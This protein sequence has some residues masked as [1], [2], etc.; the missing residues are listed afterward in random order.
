MA[1]KIITTTEAF[2]SIKQD[3]ERIEKKDKDSTY[4]STFTYCSAWWEAYKNDKN[5]ELFIVLSYQNNKIAGIA[6][7]IIENKSIKI[8]KY[9]E[10]K[11][12]GNGDFLNIIID[13]EVDN[14][15]TVVKDIFKTIED[16]KD[17]WEKMNLR[18]IKSDS[19]L[20]S[21]LLKSPEYN[22]Y[23]KYQIECPKLD[24]KKYNS[25]E[26]Y[27]KEF[28]PS[29]LNKYRN[30]LKKNTDYTIEIV[31]NKEKNVYDEISQIHKKEKEFLQ[32]QKGRSERHSL[33]EDEKREKHLRKVFEDNENVLTLILRDKENEIIGYNTFYIY[34]RVLHS[35][36]IAY[37]PKYHDY[38]VGKILKYELIKYLFE[39]KIVDTLDFGAG[40]YAWK[41]EWTDDFV[42]NY[43]LEVYNNTS[44]AKNIK[45]IYKVKHMI[46]S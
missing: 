7:L 12:L 13:S 26:E 22:K 29:K 15:L 33:F 11:F 46:K 24:I 17:K 35:W 43:E 3:W 42:F 41:F 37:N 9:K 5:K 38:R 1:S 2:Y 10:L 20:S 44:K 40:R 19:K 4:Y 18:Y 27:E 23:F 14:P 25:F 39:S 36:N 28:K 45:R 31:N 21:Y 16:N 6:P 8:T 32:S 34:K 30:K